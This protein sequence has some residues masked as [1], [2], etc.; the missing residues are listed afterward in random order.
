MGLKTF[1]AVPCCGRYMASRNLMNSLLL[2]SIM[3]LQ[4]LLPIISASD[5]NELSRIV[6]INQDDTY[7]DLELLSQIGIEPI[8]TLAH[9]WGESSG[10]NIDDQKR[11]L[12][13]QKIEVL[14]N[15]SLN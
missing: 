6:E 8:P 10:D 11:Y 14:K 2:I 13:D 9:G 1:L 3:C 5:D 15:L 4:P 7:I 12:I